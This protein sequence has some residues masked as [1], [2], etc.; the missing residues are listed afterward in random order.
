MRRTLELEEY[1]VKAND[2]GIF[3][4]KSSILETTVANR[5]ENTLEMLMT[6]GIFPTNITKDMV[7][8]TLGRA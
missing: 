8:A 3:E 2:D 7:Y 4:I 1:D 5:T 6:A